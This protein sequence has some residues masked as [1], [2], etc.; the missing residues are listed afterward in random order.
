MG[1]TPYFF[2]ALLPLNEQQMTASKDTPLSKADAVE[3][4]FDWYSQEEAKAKLWQLFTVAVTRGFEGLILTEREDL[5]TFY[6][7]VRDLVGGLDTVKP[8]AAPEDG[9]TP[10]ID[11]A[12]DAFFDQHSPEEAK[13]KLWQWFTVAVTGHFDGLSVTQKE[14]LVTFYEQV[15]DLVEG[16]A[17]EGRKQ[18]E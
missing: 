15:R 7:Q 17:V 6:E 16:L 1:S 5:I 8:G 4:F 9:E 14:D 18:S 10:L 3:A 11:K 13:A 12:T 2:A